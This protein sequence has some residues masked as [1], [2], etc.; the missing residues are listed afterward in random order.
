LVWAFDA[1]GIA[2]YY[3]IDYFHLYFSDTRAPPLMMGR[4]PIAP[5]RR[6]FC[7]RDRKHKHAGRSNCEHDGDLEGVEYAGFE[8]HHGWW[9]S[10]LGVAIGG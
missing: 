2:P 5:S 10:G 6:L 9:G 4:T 3:G 1:D 8:P 7:G